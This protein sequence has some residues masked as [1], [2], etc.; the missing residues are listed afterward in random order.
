MNCGNH[1]DP[2]INQIEHFELEM[3][4]YLLDEKFDHKHKEGY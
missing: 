3:F 1:D 4:A 2:F